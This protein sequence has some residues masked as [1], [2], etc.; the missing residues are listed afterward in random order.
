[1]SQVWPICNPMN[2]HP[3]GSSVHR[4]PR[5]ENWSGLPFYSQ[6]IFPI[7]RSNSHLM[8]LQVGSLP[9]SHEDS[10]RH[11]SDRSLYL[12]NLKS[13]R[14]VKFLWSSVDKLTGGT[15]W[16]LLVS[17]LFYAFN[18]LHVI[19]FDKWWAIALIL[20][21]LRILVTHWFIC[22]GE[23]FV[24]VSSSNYLYAILPVLYCICTIFMIV[25]QIW[26]F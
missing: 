22:W 23:N 16:N 7:Q 5:Q 3:L 26:G 10:G 15:H 13:K 24:F 19:I 20:M 14:W 25:F 17:F 4:F 18:N 6:G 11:S 1:M 8:H 12:K 2:G 9:L 21:A